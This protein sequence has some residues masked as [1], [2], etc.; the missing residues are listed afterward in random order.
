[1][2]NTIAVA[3]GFLLGSGTIWAQRYLITTVAGGSV[4]PTPASALSVQL[5]RPWAAAADAAGSV[6]FSDGNFVYK[7]DRSATLTRVAGNGMAGY[8]GDGGPATRAR[9]KLP[10]GV[11]VDAS[12][13]VYIADAGN[14]R[15]RKVAPDGTITTIAGNGT[16]GYSGDGGP[17]TSAQIKS[18]MSVFLDA[19]GDVYF[20]DSD[21]YA[22]R[23]VTPD[24][25]ITTVAIVSGA[26]GTVDA[27]GNFYEAIS[28]ANAVYKTRPDGT[29]TVV[30]GGY[31]AGYSGDG[32]PATSAQLSSPW[33]L[34]VDQA[35]NLYIADTGNYR[36]RKV[37][38]DGTITTVA[39]NGTYGS[40]GDGGQATSAGVAPQNVAV[41]AAGNLFIVDMYNRRVRKVVADGTITT[42]AGGGAGNSGD[43]GPATAAQL[44]GPRGLTADGS[45][46]FY[47]ADSGSNRIRRVGADGTI[48]TVAGTGVAGGAGDGG[49]AISAQLNAPRGVAL[50]S[51]G[52][53]YIAD[54]GNHGVRKVAPGG[55]ITTVAAIASPDG[56]AVDAAGNLYIADTT[57]NAVRK[58]AADGTITTVAQGNVASDESSD[59]VPMG[60]AVDTGGNVYAADD[61]PYWVV[62]RPGS[63]LNHVQWNS[64]IRRVAPGGAIT[65]VAGDGSSGYS[66]DGGPATEASLSYPN[67][68]A[69][70]G[71]G[72]LYIGEGDFDSDS[73]GGFVFV[74]Q[75]PGNERIR[76]VDASGTITTVAG[77]GTAGYGGDGGAAASAQLNNPSGVA[78]DSAGNVYISDSGNNAIRL[79]VPVGTRA[80]LSVTS[81]HSGYLAPGQTAATFAVVVSNAAGAGPTTGT[82][83]VKELV[84]SGLT[85]VSMAGAGWSCSSDTCTRT[86]ALPGGSSY[87]ALT[88]T[89]NV[90]ADAPS[91]V[92]NEVAV[93]GGGSSG[94]STLDAA[95]VLAPPHAPVLISPANGVTGVLASPVLS[96]GVSHGAV[97]Y[98]VYFGPSSAPSLVAH[99][100]G[101]SFVPG[102]LMADVT[103]YWRVVAV[104]PTG[105][106]SSAT[107]SFT[108]ATVTGLRFVPVPPCRVADTRGAV[109][110]F[111][112]PA[113]GSGLTRSFAIPQ[114][115]CGIP[116][117]AQAYSLN[118]TVVPKG[119]L[120]Y[121]TLWPAGQMQPLVSTLNSWDGEVVANAA[122]VPAGSG[123]AVS[124]FV[125]AAA[126]VILDVDGYFDTSSGVGSFAYY[127]V[128]PCRVA[129][130][131]YLS[132]N[133]GGIGGPAM[134]AGESREFPIASNA[135]G[136]PSGAG[137]Y[138]LNVTAIPAGY[139]GYLTTWPTGG[140]QPN[141][142]TLNSWDGKVVANAALVAAG[143]N[144]SVSVFV[145]DPT[146]VILDTD[147]YFAAPGS[148]GAL[149]FYPV[150]PC[151]VADTRGATGDFGGP[152]MEAQS[153]R[154]FTIPASA[155]L[156][157]ATAA[158]YSLNVTAVPGGV[159]SFLTTWPTGSGRPLVSTLNSF[160]GS[161]VANAAIVPAGTGGAINVFVTNRT[162]VILDINGYFAP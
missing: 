32:G 25:R 12:G 136:I 16:Y 96:W 71:A 24:G 133:F 73:T 108:T 84:S 17:A 60:V 23:R 130:T 7:V 143:T 97:S 94:S 154:T 159:L 115:G 1:M 20:T 43:G 51:A 126:D 62:V 79:L 113:V 11:A 28:W 121:L 58:R 13:S 155:C 92:E 145:E 157:P 85:L 91:Q 29:A 41:D 122:I 139:L 110:P 78:V 5:A 57:G 119:P 117:T 162:D 156:I 138:S 116:G 39:G 124:V 135:C 150:T 66:G 106:A 77:D 88:V 151:R 22:L 82:V 127:A 160:D 109:G 53:L 107:G 134:S 48:S 103:Y 158:A 90:A 63:D 95:V 72:N 131:R 161:V 44:A 30:A 33:G 104:N 153:T 40:W 102:V 15:V 98:E 118:V 68:V 37:A 146:N 36:V 46:N 81:T 4:T 144:G 19:A 2:R 38:V 80:L 59:L 132:G 9:L 47:F 142:S 10:L 55:T 14:S 26:T 70:D 54:T 123:G 148:A 6:Y 76:K 52:N 86:D 74:N 149:R 31:E 152:T 112:G 114:R 56:V 101:T 45:G 75:S 125:T 140:A 111:G 69:V 21:S 61:G 129:D 93:S 89:A 147:G 50:D 87:P 83:R 27:S 3:V 120:G 34:A 100:E 99:T 8:S 141:V 64:R 128:P 65:T 42:L 35:G 49:P 105:S 67:S 137:A 18:P